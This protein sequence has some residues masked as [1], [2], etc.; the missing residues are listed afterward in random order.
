M[1]YPEL[2]KL[3]ANCVE[4]QKNDLVINLAWKEA[5]S[6]F[7]KE[8]ELAFMEWEALNTLGEGLGK[9]DEETQ[10]SAIDYTKQQLSLCLRQARKNRKNW[11]P[12]ST[13]WA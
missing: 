5:V 9:S 12:F 2:S 3:Y 11:A 7:V 8:Q 1:H 10:L 4:R 6:E 13:S